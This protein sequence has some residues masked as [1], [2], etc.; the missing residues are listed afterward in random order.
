MIECVRRT[1]ERE[2]ER[3]RERGGESMRVDGDFILNWSTRMVKTFSFFKTTS[4][5]TLKVLSS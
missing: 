4:K 2:R 1:R 3:E 5:I